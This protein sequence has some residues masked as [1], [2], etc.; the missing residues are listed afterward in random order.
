METGIANCC[1]TWSD[2]YGATA[3]QCVMWPDNG[4][5]R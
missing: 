1:G 5:S 3:M 4:E 2:I